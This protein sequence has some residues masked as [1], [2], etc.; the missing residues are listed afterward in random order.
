MDFADKIEELAERV[1]K[2]LEY[3]TSEEATKNA[4]VMPFIQSLGYDVFNPAEVMP[5]LTADIGMKKGEKVDYAIIVG[6]EPVIAFECKKAGTN[7]HDVHASQ[8]YRY[9]SA[10]KSV[11]FGILTN[12][13]E[14][15][16]YSDL[17]ALNR[18]DDR[19]FF[20]F[21]IMNFQER[22]VAELKKF[23]KSAFDLE[24]ILATASELKYTAA[25]KRIISNEF[26]NP[27]EEFVTFLAKQVYSGRMTQPVRNQFTEITQKALRRFLNDQISYRLKSALE[28]TGQ[29]EA[30]EVKKVK[31]VIEEE[32]LLEGVV[33]EDK[34]RGIVTTEDEIEAYFAVK[35][36]LRDVMDIRRV[37]MRDAK[38]Y[39]NLLLDDSIRKPI[40]RLRFN[41]AQKYIGLFDEEKKEE[42]VAIDDV[43]EIYNYRDKIVATVEWYDSTF[44][45][46]AKPRRKKAAASAQT[47][48]YTGKSVLA[49]SFQGEKYSVN[50]WKEALLGVIEL[51]RSRDQARF[52][53]LAATLRGRKRPYFTD[54]PA[55]LRQSYQVP[56]TNLYVEVNLSSMMI[57]RICKDIV[58][59]MG[60]D[61]DDLGFEVS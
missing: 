56:N 5:E 11:R 24:E 22:Q 49:F 35:S 21:D 10:L 28:V 15:K 26:D 59:K 44:G 27:S 20:V 2:Q 57:A 17:D 9:F 46:P 53:E 8:L 48:S 34:A 55:E 39:C 43:D 47:D 12:G 3:C 4:L 33:R 51:M 19:P 16:F 29:V 42:R 13:V 45:V 50:S 14:Y 7:L 25:I 1:P 52:E 37:H 40:F 61:A 41:Q 18:M 32:D 38:S 58:V 54:D 31:E 30:D 60:Y 23:T 6:G 36:I